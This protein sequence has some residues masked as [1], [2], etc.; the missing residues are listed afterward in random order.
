MSIGTTLRKLFHHD[1]K[2]VKPD[3]I[4]QNLRTRYFDERILKELLTELFGADNYRVGMKEDEWI[5]DVPRLV[6]NDEL[7]RAKT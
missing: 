7:K 5:I 6:T 3:L 1:K 4:T 2:E